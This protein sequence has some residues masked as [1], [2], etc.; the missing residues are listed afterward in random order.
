MKAKTFYKKI[1]L[2]Q[3][4]SRIAR[5][6][7]LFHS[8]VPESWENHESSLDETEVAKLCYSQVFVILCFS[9]L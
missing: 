3:M 4:F 5:L 7:A 6:N 9:Q 8:I 2:T 1:N